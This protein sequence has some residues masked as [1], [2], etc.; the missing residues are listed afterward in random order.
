MSRL[1]VL[2]RVELRNAFEF[3]YFAQHR[4]GELTPPKRK[5]QSKGTGVALGGQVSNRAAQRA[6]LL[7]QPL[8]GQQ[9]GDRREFARHREFMLQCLTLAGRGAAAP[10]RPRRMDIELGEA[11]AQCLIDGGDEEVAAAAVE[12]G[13]VTGS[14]LRPIARLHR[15]RG[16]TPL[17]THAATR[18]RL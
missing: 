16:A 7:R 14:E 12:T 17:C 6:P 13:K 11:Q 15:P 2:V 9:L 3:A 18:S 8:R 10:E 5:T 4:G 1:L